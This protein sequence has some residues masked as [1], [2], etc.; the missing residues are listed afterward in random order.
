M[1]PNINAN[2]DVK[3]IT[4]YERSCNCCNDNQCVSD[5]CCFPF[6]RR[7]RT[8]TADCPEQERINEIAQDKLTEKSKK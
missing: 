3:P 8:H 1:I 2:A 4:D 6:L 5:C 7:R